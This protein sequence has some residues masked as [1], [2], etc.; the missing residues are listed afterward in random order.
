MCPQKTA[1]AERSHQVN[2]SVGL[3]DS[4]GTSTHSNHK[5]SH[6]GQTQENHLLPFPSY[7]TNIWIK[8]KDKA[9]GDSFQHYRIISF[10][11]S[12]FFYLDADGNAKI[13]D[14]STHSIHFP[15]TTAIGLSN[16]RKSM[17]DC[18]FGSCIHNVICI[19]ILKSVHICNSSRNVQNVTHL[20]THKNKK[21]RFK[22]KWHIQ[23]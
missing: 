6:K 1:N 18:S 8:E 12:V 11:H 20:R 13:S 23:S 16:L 4:W 21:R 9:H 10:I 14:K 19:Q 7:R 15:T 22:S 17:L 2:K 5:L 3:Q